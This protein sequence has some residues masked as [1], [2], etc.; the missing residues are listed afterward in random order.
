MLGL[1]LTILVVG[2]IAGA[3]AR[4]LVPGKQDMSIVMTI[5]LGIV[6]SFVGGFLGYLLFHKDA[7]DGFLQPAGIIGSVI[8]AVIV[9]LIWTR[10]GARRTVRADARCTRPPPPTRKEGRDDWHRRPPVSHAAVKSSCSRW[11][12]PRHRTHRRACSS[13]TRRS[14]TSA[15]PRTAPDARGL[16]AGETTGR[17]WSTWRNA[18]SDV[19]GI[20]ARSSSTAR[21]PWAMCRRTWRTARSRRPSTGASTTSTWRRTTGRP[22]CGWDRG[23][24]RSATGSSWRRRRVTA[25][26]SRPGGRSTSR[27]AGC[28][29]TASTSAAPRGRRPGRA[30]RCDSARR[31]ALGRDQGAGGGP[32]RGNRHHRPWPSGARNTP[33]GAAPPS[34]RDGSHAAQPGAVARRVVPG[35][36]R[37]SRGRGPAPGRRPDDDQDRVASQLAGRCRAFTRHL[38]RAVRR[39]GAHHCC[40]LVGAVPPRG[41]GDPHRRRRRAP[42]HADPR[43]AEPDLRSPRPRDSWPATASTPRRSSPC[44]SEDCREFRLVHSTNRCRSWSDSMSAPR[45]S[46]AVR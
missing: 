10:V 33:R 21:R 30:R 8:G 16:P 3:L 17:E 43:R 19:S 46:V 15:R 23:C 18:D 25:T 32:G 1:I 6:G 45:P 24:R 22:S 40:R 27:C 13:P 28:R 11:T 31:R 12:R 36:L 41:D 38:V 35:R 5:V 29:P 26:G 44:P 34:L 7:A 9:L 4:L 14:A 37:G 42:G 20:R 39:P 2:L